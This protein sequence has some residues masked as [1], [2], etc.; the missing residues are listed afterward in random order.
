MAGSVDKIYVFSAAVV[1]FG[2]IIVSLGENEKKTV[3]EDVFE[4]LGVSQSSKNEIRELISGYG[5]RP[6]ATVCGKSRLHPLFVF[7]DFAFD[8]S[9]C[10][11]VMPAVSVRKAADLAA[12]GAFE[13][14]IISASLSEL[15]EENY[16]EALFRNKDEYVH[17]SRIFG[18]IMGLMELKLQYTA[19]S[20][21]IF[22]SA[23]ESVSELLGISLNFDTYLDRDNEDLVATDEI[24]DGRFCAAVLLT[25]AMI[26][27]RRAKDSALDVTVINGMG[28]VKVEMSFRCHRYVN[29]EA[30]DHLKMLAEINH[31]ILFDVTKK[32]GRV[33]VSFVP[34]Y[35]D[36]GFVGVKNGDVIFN[37][38]DYLES[39]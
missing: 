13:D 6:Y 8:T 28:G 39:H 7:K 33:G 2:R 35:Q 18:Q 17:L 5:K 30:L 11:A 31:G 36:V 3:D 34:L 25:F 21:A 4:V 10:L 37:I 29:L 12:C 32:D 14:M 27:A 1:D 16:A 22:R 20:P 9:L 24:F 38:V 15:A 19:Q 26:A 23:A